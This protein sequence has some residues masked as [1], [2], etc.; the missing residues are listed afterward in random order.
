MRWGALLVF[1]RALTRRVQQHPLGCV[2][3]LNPIGNATPAT[4]PLCLTERLPTFGLERPLIPNQR[5]Y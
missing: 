4:H 3:A 1:Q 2:A 5:A